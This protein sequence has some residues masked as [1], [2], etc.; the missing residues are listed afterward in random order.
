MI[1]PDLIQKM[2][3]AGLHNGRRGTLVCA[4]LFVIGA[5]AFLIGVLSSRPER[6]WQAYHVNFMFWIG[7]CFGG[8][9]FSALQSMSDGWRNR[10][11]KRLGESFGVFLPVACILFG[12]LYLGRAHV[13][14]WFHHAPPR[15]AGWLNIP[16]LFLRDGA[17][18]I[19]LTVLGL[20]IVRCSV[21]IDRRGEGD[22]ERQAI[23]RA[24]GRQ[25]VLSVIYGIGYAF[26]L[27]L[28]AFDLLM[29]LEP[30]FHSTLFGAWYFMGSFYTAISAVILLTVYGIRKMGM[31]PFV[32]PLHLL[33]VGR[34]LMG[35]CLI[36]GDFFFTQIM[37]IWYA[38]LPE[39][40]KYML[41]R[42][43]EQPWSFFGWVVLFCCYV[44]PFGILLSRKVKMKP[45]RM[46]CLSILI[47]VGFWIERWMLVAPALWKGK[48][49]P[50]GITEILV[51]AGFAGL[52]LLCIRWFLSRYP[53][54]PLRDPMFLEGI[55]K[56]KE[57]SH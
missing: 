43:R 44:I 11:M 24:M 16:F 27:S 51:T 38:N 35:F 52:V 12:I 42:L 15:I 33:T 40:T 41:F 1:S 30:H 50:L 19:L 32:K 4:A 2:K 8:V 47:L 36:T 31:E 9:L 22:E 18:L 3:E 7:L 14:P 45:L 25:K 37:I 39:E 17:A 54:L 56:L 28:L 34:L 57:G 49:L 20:A 23:Q 5:A 48:T 53:V 26:L 10:P 46:A 55:A 13:F 29:S 6:A 21:R